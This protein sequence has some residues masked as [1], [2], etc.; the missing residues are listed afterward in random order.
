MFSKD[1]I[2]RCFSQGRA[3]AVTV[4]NWKGP[5]GY[6]T[7]KRSLNSKLAQVNGQLNTCQWIS[8][9]RYCSKWSLIPDLLGGARR[10][11]DQPCSVNESWVRAYSR[12]NSNNWAGKAFCSR[13]MLPRT[14]ALCRGFRRCPRYSISTR[15]K[16]EVR[17][18]WVCGCYRGERR[19]SR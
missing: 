8:R 2:G 9:R 13:W 15:S 3:A 14:V 6:E 7:F 18:S 4:E 16:R 10:T 11:G 17:T 1:N 5:R 12:R 19:V